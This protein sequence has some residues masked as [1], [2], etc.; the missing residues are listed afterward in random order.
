MAAVSASMAED[1]SAIVLALKAKNKFSNLDKSSES[2]KT[3][4]EAN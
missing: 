3:S 1:Y 2:A 4:E